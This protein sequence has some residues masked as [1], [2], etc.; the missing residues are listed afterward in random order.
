MLADENLDHFFHDGSDRKISQSTQA[1]M[2]YYKAVQD[3]Q[4]H[5]RFVPEEIEVGNNH[6]YSKKWYS[7]TT[8]TTKTTKTCDLVTR[9]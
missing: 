9:K 1:Y 4:Q 2:D 6:L 8:T 3:L 5:G 7:P